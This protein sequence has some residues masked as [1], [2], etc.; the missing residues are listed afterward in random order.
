MVRR[1]SA[2][3][4]GAI[5]GIPWGS[6]VGALAGWISDNYVNVGLSRIGS[7]WVYFGAFMLALPVGMIGGAVGGAIFVKVRRRLPGQTLG[8]K[9]IVFSVVVW[10]FEV[11]PIPALG[12]GRAR[13][14]EFSAYDLVMMNALDLVL[15]LSWGALFAFFYGRDMTGSSS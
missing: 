7:S 12:W 10:L 13:A 4:W 2:L 6:G 14:Y 3:K 11:I 8:V 5:A 9:A 1:F 15:L